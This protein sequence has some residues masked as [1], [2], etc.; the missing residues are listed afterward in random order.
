MTRKRGGFALLLLGTVIAVAVAAMVFRQAQEAAATARLESVEVIVAATDIPERSLVLGPQLAVKRML[1]ASLPPNALTRP[2]QAIGKMTT[3]PVLAGEFVLPGKLV[4]GDGRAGIAFSVPRG[5]VVITMPASDILSTGAVQVGD[6]V[7][8]L[9]TVSPPDRD[10][11]RIAGSSASGASASATPVAS[12]T[13]S[14]V[15]DLPLATTQTTMQG[16]KV[17]GIGSMTAAAPRGDGKAAEPKERPNAATGVITF[18]VEPQD[19]LV[20]KA[21]KDSDRVRLELVLRAAGDD[22]VKATDPVTLATILE[23][24]QF[25]SVATPVARAGAGR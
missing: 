4:D 22:A 21:L 3:G 8:L 19:A 24:Y 14:S 16:L 15:D 25:R 5:R 18:A 9:V 17:L 13:P 6:T 10:D 7:D 1:P 12:P 23:R 2:E 20:L 11:R